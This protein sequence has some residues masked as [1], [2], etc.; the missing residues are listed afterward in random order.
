MVGLAFWHF[1]V[2]FPDD[3]AGGIVGARC[4]PRSRAAS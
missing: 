2:F 3:F 1:T 4:W